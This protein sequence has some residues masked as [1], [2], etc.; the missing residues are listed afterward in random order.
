M[1][2]FLEIADDAWEEVLK[3]KIKEHILET[4]NK[5]MEEL[6]KIVSEGN[7]ERWKNKME[8]RRG[9]CSFKEKLSQFFGGGSCKS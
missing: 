2:Y 6:A 9:C 5:K 7:G 1:H 4:Q 8:K 3:E